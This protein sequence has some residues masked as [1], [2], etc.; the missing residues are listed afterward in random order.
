MFGPN[1]LLIVLIGSWP[2][3]RAGLLRQEQ[4]YQGRTWARRTHGEASSSNAQNMLE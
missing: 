1:V 3:L 4:L 2:C